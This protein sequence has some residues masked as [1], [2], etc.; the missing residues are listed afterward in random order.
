MAITA[1]A[2]VLSFNVVYAS[3]FTRDEVE[4]ASAFLKQCSH[5]SN[6]LGNKYDLSLEDPSNALQSSAAILK[7][8]VPDFVKND[9]FTKNVKGNKAAEVLALGKELGQILKEGV[10]LNE[11][12]VQDLIGNRDV[13]SLKQVVNLIVDRFCMKDGVTTEVT[14]GEVAAFMVFRKRM[15]DFKKT[16]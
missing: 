8:G 13:N 11:I 14:S 16:F 1:L 5:T 9:D 6:A 7:F 10:K 15:I 2:T 4:G 12:D 3:G